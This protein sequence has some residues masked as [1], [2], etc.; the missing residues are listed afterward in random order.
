M[1]DFKYTNY[2]ISSV[3]MGSLMRCIGFKRNIYV[4]YSQLKV[5]FTALA[6]RRVGK[7]KTNSRV[8]GPPTADEFLLGSGTS[9][10]LSNVCSSSRARSP[11]QLIN[12]IVS[13][14]RNVTKTQ[15]IC[16]R[17]VKRRTISSITSN[18]GTHYARTVIKYKCP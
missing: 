1:K 6:T 8:S 7:W 13:L 12:R 15:P 16:R 3:G 11:R 2:T 14:S 10:P 18:T 4:I 9:L 5:G 17:T